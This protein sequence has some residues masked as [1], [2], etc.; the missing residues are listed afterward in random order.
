MK[1]TLWGN[2]LIKHEIY[3]TWATCMCNIDYTH[4]YNSWAL[5]NINI[6]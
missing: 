5:I 6:L 2:A 1:H 4:S 3:T